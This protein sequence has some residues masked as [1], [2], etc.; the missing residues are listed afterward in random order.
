MTW[1]NSWAKRKAITLTGGS[2]GLDADVSSNAGT[3]KLFKS[4]ISDDG[5]IF[6]KEEY[7]SGA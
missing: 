2:S 6:K 7:V 1:Y 3:I 5:V 4:A